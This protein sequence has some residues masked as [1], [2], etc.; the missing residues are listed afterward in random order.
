MVDGG[1]WV[2]DG[3]WWDAGPTRVVSCRKKKRRGERHSV[4]FKG[5]CG[6]WAAK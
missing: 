3:G 6:L 4:A 2:V 5:L 1:W